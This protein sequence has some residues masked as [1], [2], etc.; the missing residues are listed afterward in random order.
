MVRLDVTLRGVN[1]VTVPAIVRNVNFASDAISWFQNWFPKMYDLAG[2]AIFEDSHWIWPKLWLALAN[3]PDCECLVIEANGQL[4]ALCIFQFQNYTGDDGTDC[5]YVKFVAVAP[6]NR[7][8]LNAHT[9]FQGLGKLFLSIAALVRAARIQQLC[10]LELE[11]LPQAEPFYLHI[12]F[13]PTGVVQGTLNQYRLATKNVT[14]LV[15]SQLPFI[16]PGGVL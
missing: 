4:Q 12:G 16:T 9:R 6:W 8:S 7:S 2:N 5:A 10:P 3:D 14:S 1:G 13:V 11:S 15:G